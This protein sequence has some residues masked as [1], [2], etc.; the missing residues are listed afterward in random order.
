[1]MADQSESAGAAAEPARPKGTSRAGI[2]VMLAV[3]LA[4]LG[5][6]AWGLKHSQAGPRD[7]GKAPDFTLTG[8]DGRTV[9]LSKLRGQVVVINF[10]ASWCVPC[11]QEAAY[12]ERT[13]RKYKD[14]G[15]VFIGVDYAD[16]EKGARAYIQEFDI[17]YINGPDLG[18]RIS[19]AFNI[20]GVPETYYVDKSG[21]LRG[22]NIGPLE[23]PQLDQKI[24]E[25]LAETN[26]P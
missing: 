17:T 2:V 25:L 7:S 10:W 12:L 1:M 15:V 26:E 3:L 24:D 9:T 8:Y 6:L 23:S 5:L 22:V 16:T 14:R 11:R 20:K 4:L 21:V 19:Q 18:T 13:W